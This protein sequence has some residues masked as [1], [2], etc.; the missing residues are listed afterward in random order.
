MGIPSGDQQLSSKHIGS[1][2]KDQH[3][4]SCKLSFMMTLILR[5]AVSL[6]AQVLI[7][8]ASLFEDCSERNIR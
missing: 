8:V 3:K 2:L 6:D 4:H 1:I 5:I 7:S